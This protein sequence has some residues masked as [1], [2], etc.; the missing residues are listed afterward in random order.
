M[1]SWQEVVTSIGVVTCYG[2]AGA[3]L[4]RHGLW[5]WQQWAALIVAAL[6]MGAFR[7]E[8]QRSAKR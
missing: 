7:S 8:A 6:F 5:S 3:M 1:W 4:E 2:V